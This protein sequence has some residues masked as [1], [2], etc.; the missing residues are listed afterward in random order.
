MS[1]AVTLKGKAAG[2]EYIAT[3]RSVQR[4]GRLKA[5]PAM[6]DDELEL[7]LRDHRRAFEQDLESV[8]SRR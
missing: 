2:G 8:W 6:S 3:F 1:A 5:A 7:V 4:A